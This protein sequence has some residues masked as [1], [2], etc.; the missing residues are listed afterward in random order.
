MSSTLS[1]DPVEC[2]LKCILNHFGD[3]LTE[4][5]LRKYYTT[6]IEDAAGTDTLR[7]LSSE[8]MEGMA[9]YDGIGIEV[10]PLRNNPDEVRTL[11]GVLEERIVKSGRRSQR[12]SVKEL[13]IIRKRIG[14]DE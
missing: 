5:G 6:V 8:T 13:E 11:Q 7:F 12:V 9:A 3:L 14:V 1:E 2:C 4:R 10:I